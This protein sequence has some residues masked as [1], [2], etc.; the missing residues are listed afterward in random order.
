MMTVYGNAQ[1][2]H[3]ETVRKGE[4]QDAETKWRWL[5]RPIG[6]D[7]G[8]HSGVVEIDGRRYGCQCSFVSVEGDS[9]EHHWCVVDLRSDRGDTYRLTFGDD[10]ET[11]DCAHA[12]FR[13]VSCKHTNAIR[14]AL[15]D[16]DEYDRLAWECETSLAAVR[17]Y[18][19]DEAPF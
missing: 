11:C 2:V 13:G 8:W 5:K 17:P 12:T 9:G 18:M 7:R 16:Q 15:A 19:G 6:R 3:S 10:G 14:H 1:T 4:V